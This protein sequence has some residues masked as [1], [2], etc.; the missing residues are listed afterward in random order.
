[1]ETHYRRFKVKWLVNEAVSFAIV[2]E[3]TLGETL[4]KPSVADRLY[5][6]LSSYFKVCFKL[7][8][9]FQA[10]WTVFKHV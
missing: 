7:G 10:I 1:V 9:V 2:Y 5:F 4:V 8:D 3:M 6:A